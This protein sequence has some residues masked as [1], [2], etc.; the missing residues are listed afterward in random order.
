[1]YIYSVVVFWEYDEGNQQVYHV[2]APECLEE[3]EVKRR[4]LKLYSDALDLNGPDAAE[5]HVIVTLHLT[6]YNV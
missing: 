6:T 4:F 2:V 1:M 3:S 5:Q